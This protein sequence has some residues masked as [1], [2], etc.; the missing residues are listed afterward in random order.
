MYNL[1]ISHNNKPVDEY[2]LRQEIVTIG[3]GGENDIQLIDTTVSQRHAQFLVSADSLFIIDMDST[4]GTYVNGQRITR[5]R[6]KNGDQVMIGQHQLSFDDLDPSE[7]VDEQEPTLQ[8]SR[9]TIEQMLFHSQNKQGSS[10]PPPDSNKAINWVAQDQ[11]GVWWG[12]EQQPVPD[13][14][15][16]ANFQDTMKLK[17][18]QESPNPGWRETLHKV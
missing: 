18:K 17:L 6:L 3:R 15:G 13:S 7:E 1:T 10:S 9:N 5:H 14:A 8:M 4:N 2:I 11:N 16:W 12:F